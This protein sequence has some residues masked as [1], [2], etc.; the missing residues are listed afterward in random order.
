MKKI[1]LFVGIALCA[2]SK[3]NDSGRN[4]VVIGFE[5]RKDGGISEVVAAKGGPDVLKQYEN[6][7]GVKIFYQGETRPQANYLTVTIPGETDYRQGIYIRYEDGPVPDSTYQGYIERL[8]G[9]TWK[10]EKKTMTGL[11]RFTY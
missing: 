9:S 1:L 5:K 3:D 4:G 10:I 2:C 7:S 11:E 8:K 6:V